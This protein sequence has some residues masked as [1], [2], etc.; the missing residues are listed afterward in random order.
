MKSFKTTTLTV[1]VGALLLVLAVGIYMGARRFSAQVNSRIWV[2]HTYQV[3]RKLD[4]LLF[5]LKSVEVSQRDFILFGDDDSL[6]TCD[7]FAKE[8]ENQIKQISEL[9]QDDPSQTGKL[10][11]LKITSRRCWPWCAAQTRCAEPKG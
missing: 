1:L 4:S 5:D 7:L 6:K 9:V 8:S 2:V 3:L 11:T 10:A